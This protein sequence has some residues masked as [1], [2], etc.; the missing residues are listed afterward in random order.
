MNVLSRSCSKCKQ[1]KPVVEFYKDKHSKDGFD[2]QCKACRKE[3][4]ER[5]KV[6]RR[7]VAL[8]YRNKNVE[9]C[10]KRARQWKKDNAERVEEY[11][12]KY[13]EDNA[14]YFVRYTKDYIASGRNRINWQARKAREALLV[15]DFTAAEWVLCQEFF[16]NACAYCGKPGPLAQDHVVPVCSGGGYTISNIVPACKWCNTSKAARGWIIWFRSRDFYN[17]EREE[18]IRYYLIVMQEEPFKEVKTN[19]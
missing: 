14:D 3:Y 15:S 6:E 12:R 17:P 4:Y 11:N 5:T 1:E 10:R 7:K 13:R 9:D 19:G 2:L 16:D 8:A 18:L